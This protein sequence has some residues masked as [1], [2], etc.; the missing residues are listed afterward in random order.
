MPKQGLFRDFRAP[1]TAKISPVA[2]ALIGMIMTSP[3]NVG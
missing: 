1:A 3:T 2:K